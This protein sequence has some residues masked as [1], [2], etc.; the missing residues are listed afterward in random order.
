MSCKVQ[1]P[2]GVQDNVTL[3]NSAKLAQARVLDK[4]GNRSRLWDDVSGK[5]PVYENLEQAFVPFANSYARGVENKGFETYEG[6]NEPKLFFQSTNGSIHEDYKSALADSDSEGMLSF[7]FKKGNHLSPIGH[8]TTSINPNTREGLING[9][10]KDGLLTGETL[11][12]QKGNLYLQAEGKTETEQLVNAS[13][14][15]NQVEA[16]GI[17]Y[18]HDYVNGTVHVT[19]NNYNTGVKNSKGEFITLEDVTN[20][21]EGYVEKTSEKEAADTL[22][23]IMMRDG[24]YDKVLDGFANLNVDSNKEL[25]TRLFDIINQSGITLMTIENYNKRYTE[26]HGKEMDAVALAD[27]AN[28]VIALSEDATLDDLTEEV[29]HFV[30]EGMLESEI[31]TL[32]NSDEFLKSREYAEHYNTYKDIYER[33]GYE[34]AELDMKTKKEILGKML[35]NG[36]L[37]QYEN[38]LLTEPASELGFFE[39]LKNFVDKI[40]AKLKALL[41][42]N[43]SALEQW[44]SDLS[45]RLLND[46][47]ESILN[48]KEIQSKNRNTLNPVFYATNAN[49]IVLVTLKDTLDALQGRLQRIRRA[50]ITDVEAYQYEV[51]KAIQALEDNKTQLAI[52]T[53]VTIAESMAN[54]TAA[55]IKRITNGHKGVRNEHLLA[56]IR[57][58]ET[59]MIPTLHELQNS[60]AEFNIDGQEKAN[61]DRIISQVEALANDNKRK[62][63]K[64]TTTNVE[65]Q[66]KELLK[67]YNI[68]EEAYYHIA[69]SLFGKQKDISQL[70]A[71]LGN[72]E[73][74]AHY[75]IGMLGK[76][77]ANNGIKTRAIMNQLAGGIVDVL[78]K[79]NLTHE[80]QKQ[81]IERTAD[82]GDSGNF[83]SHIN[84]A[85]AEAAYHGALLNAYNQIKHGQDKDSYKTMEEYENDGFTFTDLDDTQQRQFNDEKIKIDQEYLNTRY[86]VDVYNK[87]NA[88]YNALGMG[89]DALDFLRSNSARRHDLLKKIMDKDGNINIEAL[90]SSK[91]VLQDLQKLASEKSAAASLT[92]HLTGEVYG[93]V[94]ESKM[95]DITYTYEDNN[96]KK[97]TETFKIP[98]I[99]LAPG[100]DINDISVKQAVDLV[101][102]NLFNVARF[103]NETRTINDN[104]LK[105]VTRIEDIIAQK[106]G[107]KDFASFEKSS[108]ANKSVVYQEINETL[109]DFV[110][111]TGALSFTES[112]Y[113]NLSTEPNAPYKQ[114]LEEIINDTDDDVVK[115]TAERLK[116]LMTKR[117]NLL[118]AYR[119]KLNFA[120]IDSD[121]LSDIDKQHIRELDNDIR[122]LKR[123]LNG[124]VEDTT[125]GEFRED[126]SSYEMNSAFEQDLK[127][128]GKSKLDFM[129]ENSINPTK[130]QNI[131]N[132]FI[133]AL[134]EG[135]LRGGKDIIRFLEEQNVL[136]NGRLSANYANILNDQAQIEQLV[137]KYMIRNMPSFYTRFTPKG[138][139]SWKRLLDNKTYHN[140]GKQA[141]FGEFLRN[142]VNE[143][144]IGSSK[145]NNPVEQYITVNPSL[146]YTD[147]NGKT[148]KEQINEDFDNDSPFG[149]RQFKSD[150]FI[151]NKFFETFSEINKE[152]YLKMNDTERWDYLQNLAKTTNNGKLALYVEALKANKQAYENYGLGSKYSIYRRPRI[153]KNEVESKIQTISDPKA[154]VTAWFTK[155]FKQDV[156]KQDEGAI[157]EGVNLSL[158]TDYKTMPKRGIYNLEDMSDLSQDIA[159]SALQFLHHSADYKVKEETLD[160]ALLIGSLI[161]GQ[162]FR[163]NLKGKE[164]QVKKMYQSFLDS[165][166]YGIKKVGRLELF[167]KDISRIVMWLSDIIGRVNTSWSFWVGATGH[168]SGKVFT[169]SEAI[170]GQYF[171]MTDWRKG[172][173][174][175][176]AT[177]SKNLTEAGKVKRT[178]KLYLTMR[179]LGIQGYGIENTLSATGFGRTGRALLTESGYK[180]ADF[181]TEP[182]RHEFTMAIL[183]A[184][185]LYKGRWMSKAQYEN[186]KRRE[187]AST[188]EIEAEYNSLPRLYDNYIVNDK[189]GLEVSEQG[190]KLALAEFAKQN[191][192]VEESKLHT[193]LDKDADVFTDVGTRLISIQTNLEG[194][195]D[196]EQKSMASR[197]WLGRAFLVNRNWFFNR[198]QR[199]F[200]QTHFNYITG[201][202]EGGGLTSAFK[203]II[204]NFKKWLKVADMAD[205][206]NWLTKSQL[207]ILNDS[208]L[209]DSE[210]AAM[211]EHFRRMNGKLT[212][213]KIGETSIHLVAGLLGMMLLAG[214]ARDDE[215]KQNWMLQ[216]ALYIYLRTVSELGSTQIHTG[217]PQALEMMKTPTMVMNPF[218]DLFKSLST[219]YVKS[220]T[221]KDVPKIL[222]WFIKY[223]P[224]RQVFMHEDPFRSMSTYAFHNTASLGFAKFSNAK[225]FEAFLKDDGDYD[226]DEE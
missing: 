157:Q 214:F 4:D 112:F 195:V 105:E 16:Q 88:V 70:Y 14:F 143:K 17:D 213:Q 201:Q 142:A 136:D 185:K 102:M 55:D 162:T 67:K 160:D 210:R 172:V 222:Q 83:I 57:I 133:K 180:M 25:A 211:T 43:M 72:P 74:S 217:G 29:S 6:T 186:L 192:G 154:A 32:V 191:P 91:F 24:E 190:K 202:Y 146:Q 150:K 78:D 46:R 104:Y 92:N 144:K 140:N 197:H 132:T 200:K 156:E 97:I 125:N 212:H 194:T 103:Q 37:T 18:S 53:V 177:A 59:Q 27:V 84:L 165:H 221:Y 5:V 167:G 188:D 48:L 134:T 138:Y 204:N 155:N 114:R 174:S 176:Y 205:A 62:S 51:K 168:T 220:G 101:N 49:K 58:M 163:G 208:N 31:E 183:N 26:I 52:H 164:S 82:G 44:Q 109:L 65:Q 122:T 66:V 115:D 219:D 42:N 9:G 7:G 118:K 187:G 149:G 71:F 148:F 116:T 111:A 50:N 13:I 169:L 218:V 36:I 123:E 135:K 20:D 147:G 223:S 126:F 45:D 19:E 158:G 216:S 76:I 152:Q 77:I 119:N 178:D 96:G 108:K 93:R 139:D 75:A 117:A 145:F 159:S 38:R 1:F 98:T 127:A 198:M 35:A 184:T 11:V 86:T 131:K 28:G 225:D 137:E 203:V 173:L 61:L 121:E 33:Q 166:W 60:F 124:M 179:T 161:D 207:N 129:I 95:R 15:R 113:S 64:V 189:G 171:N 40:V 141:S 181:L 215:D 68:P 196:Q 193:L 10:I 54:K 47:V 73:H 175:S 107:Y 182:N 87:M 69:Q 130:Y 41:P 224:V 94:N 106:Y 23:E 30:V 12:D 170:A 85:E 79:F 99:E 21:Y 206:E 226:D 151:N 56:D 199:D 153:R 80:D 3:D 100:V 110:Q 209:S 89:Q 81:L 90:K 128:S 63:L 8:V 2:A 34:G 39:N 22:V 120:E